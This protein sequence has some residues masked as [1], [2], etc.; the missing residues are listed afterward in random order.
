[1][2]RTTTY[3]LTDAT[4]GERVAFS[5]TVDVT[6]ARG[7]IVAEPG[8]GVTIV[9]RDPP[10]RDDLPGAEWVAPYAANCT[11][12]GLI[13]CRATL[14]QATGEAREHITREHIT[15]SDSPR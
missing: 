2:K 1:M 15:H 13:T 10:E 5:T 9:R 6:P 8:A 7:A 4:T 3:Q 11:G 14:E 12:H